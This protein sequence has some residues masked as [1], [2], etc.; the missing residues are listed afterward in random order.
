VRQLFWLARLGRQF[1]HE[2]GR[3]I[4]GRGAAATTVQFLLE[5]EV[6]VS[7]PHGKR[8][9]RAPAAIGVE[10]VLEGSPMQSTIVASERS[11]TLSLTSDEFL[12]LLSENV[13]LAEGIFRMMI[14][15][16]DL[17]AGN[18]L[19]RG[20]LPA[21]LKAGAEEE[22]RPID[23]VFL[24]QSSPLLAHATAAQ[25]WRLSAIARPVTAAA[26]KEIVQRGDAPS[27]VIVLSGLLRV[28]S[29]TV[30]TADTGDVIGMYETLAGVPIDATVTAETKAH[31]LR[32]DRAGLFELLADHTELLQGVFS[33]LLRAAASRPPADKP[34][35]HQPA[36]ER[37]AGNT[38]SNT[39][40]TP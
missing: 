29:G 30:E 39:V 13:E 21:D 38:I 1:R 20:T 23:R 25:L 24:L 31:F 37:S 26:G 16:R 10:E 28:E 14:V 27:I 9:V 4:Y 12:A 3:T 11:I 2:S 8:D 19:I 17:V 33:I 34:A 22:L 32:V 5:G 18:T 6:T 35:R 7:G 15:S 40:S 36:L